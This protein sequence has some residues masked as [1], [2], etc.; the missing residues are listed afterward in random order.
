VLATTVVR[1]RQNGSVD[2]HQVGVLD[3]LEGAGNYRAWLI[4]SI[5]PHVR[6]RVLEVGAGTGSYSGALRGLG[7]SLTAVEPSDASI[8]ILRARLAPE[9]DTE[10]VHGTEPPAGSCFDAIVLL[11]VLEHIDDDLGTLQRLCAATARDGR[12]VVWV[13]AFELLMS[14]FDRSVGHVRRYRRRELAGVLERAGY[15]V[16]SCRYRNFVGFFGW[17]VAARLLRRSPS[18]RSVRWYDRT[19][20][21][22]VRWV[23]KRIAVPFGQSVLAVATPAGSSPAGG[24][25]A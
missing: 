23:E 18:P 9:Q 20:V 7:E 8:D 14:D 2:A 24:A 3:D 6:G 17:L 12:I 15:E 4:E 11:N 16:V 13:P 1:V 22:I 25:E 19:V 5:A 10:V 21:P